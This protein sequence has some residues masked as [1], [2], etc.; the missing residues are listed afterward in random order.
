MFSL[1]KIRLSIMQH[2]EGEETK[3]GMIIPILWVRIKVQGEGSELVNTAQA[4]MV[5]RQHSMAALFGSGH[6]HYT[7]GGARAT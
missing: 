4:S 7:D 2:P 1:A 5:P 6:V 3:V